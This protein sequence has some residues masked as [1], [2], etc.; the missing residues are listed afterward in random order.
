MGAIAPF[1]DKRIKHHQIPHCFKFYR[2]GGKCIMQYKL[3]STNKKWLPVSPFEATNN[4]VIPKES[5]AEILLPDYVLINGF[6]EF[7]NFVGVTNSAGNINNENLNS[8]F[9]INSLYPEFVDLQ[10]RVIKKMEAIAE[11]ESDGYA[12]FKIENLEEAKV[13]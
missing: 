3:F 12:D 8:I 4:Q 10:R 11:A 2:L 5:T 9:V 6:D 7:L 13:C 1:I